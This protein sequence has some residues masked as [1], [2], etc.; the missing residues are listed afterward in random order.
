MKYSHKCKL[1]LRNMRKK[2]SI[3]VNEKLVLIGC[4]KTI[5]AV[6]QDL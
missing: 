2:V 6:L 4:S 1:N 3:L 5:I